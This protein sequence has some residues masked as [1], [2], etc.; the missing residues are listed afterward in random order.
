M[1]YGHG[2][3]LSN[4][5]GGGRVREF[6]RIIIVETVRRKRAHREITFRRFLLEIIYSLPSPL[7]QKVL[8]TRDG[9]VKPLSFNETI[10]S[11]QRQM[12]ECRSS[13][14]LSLSLSLSFFYSFPDNQT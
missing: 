12:I 8:L 9:T 10:F 14:S 11:Q 7:H 2:S 3:G 1:A 13:L 5:G 4:R 6:S